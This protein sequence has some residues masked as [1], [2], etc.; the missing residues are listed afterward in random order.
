MYVDEVRHNIEEQF[1]DGKL[2]GF[3][4][5]LLKGYEPMLEIA[6]HH[7]D[8]FVSLYDECKPAKSCFMQFQLRWH[9]WC[10]AF[11]LEEKYTLEAINLKE[12]DNG[13]SSLVSIRNTWLEFCKSCNT[14]VPTSNPVMIAV[15]SSLYAYLLNHVSAFQESVTEKSLTEHTE[16]FS[17]DG[18]DVYYRFGG[19]ALCVMLKN[20]YNE[21]K[22]CPSSVRNV[23]SVEI[24]M[25]QAMKIKDKSGIP[26]YLRY[27]DKG[28]MYFPDSSLVPFLRNFDSILKE[29]V[30][31]EGLRKHGDN[32]IKVCIKRVCFSY[33][34]CYT[35]HTL[36]QSSLYFVICSTSFF[37]SCFH[38]W[39]AFSYHCSFQ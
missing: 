26:D 37:P 12:S 28:F 14:P 21:I 20:R 23:L 16:A 30:N 35:V 13:Y 18:D 33:V 32:L 19:A 5:T 36:N 34:Y 8:S 4:E 17:G 1:S 22:K 3:V 38:I 27:R 11:L 10:S 24:F 7:R 29:I 31:E 2:N 9:S 6:K 39:L 25:L 15:S